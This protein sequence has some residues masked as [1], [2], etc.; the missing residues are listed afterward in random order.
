MLSTEN[1]HFHLNS[2]FVKFHQRPHKHGVFVSKWITWTNQTTFK[3][4]FYLTIKTR[5]LKAN[6]KTN[7]CTFMEMLF[8]SRRTSIEF[9]LSSFYLF[10]LC[11][12][13]MWWTKICQRANYR[14]M[15]GL[16]HNSTVPITTISLILNAPWKFH[17][18]KA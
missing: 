11:R 16:C 2:I 7:K 17:W 15:N 9:S 4:A 14:N 18:I 10:Y 13:S 12:I 1:D 5:K 6:S 8:H 3:H